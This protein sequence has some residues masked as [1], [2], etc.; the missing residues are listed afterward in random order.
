VLK[1]KLHKVANRS[2][3][4]KTD[5]PR[6]AAARKRSSVRVPLFGDPKRPPVSI[7]NDDIA[8]ILAEEDAES[9][10]RFIRI[11]RNLRPRKPKR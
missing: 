2:G 5:G 3:A 10:L 6:K 4:S 7:S 1:N 9:A 11:R 8:R